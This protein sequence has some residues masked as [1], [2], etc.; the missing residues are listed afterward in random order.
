MAPASWPRWP[1]PICIAGI[2]Q[3]PGQAIA[4]GEKAGLDMKAVLDVISKGRG[5]ELAD[6]HRGP[7]M[8][9]GQFDFGFAVD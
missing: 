9:Q 1:I 3:G 2:V 7:T 8:V 5:P 6:G 4:F